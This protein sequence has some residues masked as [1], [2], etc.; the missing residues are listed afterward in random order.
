MNLLVFAFESAPSARMFILTGDLLY[1]AFH[2][3]NVSA[4]PKKKKAETT[5]EN[6][7]LLKGTSQ[8]IQ[9][10]LRPYKN[11]NQQDK[12]SEH[13]QQKVPL[14]FVELCLATPI[15]RNLHVNINFAQQRLRLSR[16]TK[17]PTR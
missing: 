11:N 17:L 14:D 10:F 15:G 3:S 4:A 13:I 2:V 8:A 9:S 12:P 1:L 5:I 6:K 16:H 7:F